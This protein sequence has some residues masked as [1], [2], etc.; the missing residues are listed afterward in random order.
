MGLAPLAGTGPDLWLASPDPTPEPQMLLGF[1]ETV[2]IS[3]IKTVPN[4]FLPLKVQ[5]SFH[6]KNIYPTLV[7]NQTT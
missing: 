6:L 5:N 7:L 2:L 4:D 1:S 3:E